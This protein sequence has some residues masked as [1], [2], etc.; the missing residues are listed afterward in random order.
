MHLESVFK[1]L[2]EANLKIKP[3]KCEF[4]KNEVNFLGFTIN[5]FGVKKTIF[6]LK[7]IFL[8]RCDI[9]RQSV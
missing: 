5:E 3:K 8:R 7:T 9:C 1:R 2:N 6:L 4:G